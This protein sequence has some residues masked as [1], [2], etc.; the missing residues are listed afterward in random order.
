VTDRRTIDQITSDQLDQLY[1]QIARVQALAEEH[2]AGI[3]TALIHEALAEQPTRTTPN[4]PPTSTPDTWPSRRAGLRNEI[5]AAIEAAD[6]SGNM[7]RGDLAD[8]VM[9]VLYREWPWLRAEAEPSPAATEATEQEKATRAIA[10]HE[11]WVKAGPPPLGVS[12]SRWWDARLIELHD[13]ILPTF[14]QPE[15][16]Q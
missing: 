15:E 3:D 12:L 16:Q 13:A 10:L 8:S 2:P 9:P 1:D 7:R 4:N 6:Y 11:R 14:E 5:A